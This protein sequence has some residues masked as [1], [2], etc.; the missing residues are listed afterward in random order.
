M[1]NDNLTDDILYH[2][3]IRER[4]S[5]LQQSTSITSND[6]NYHTV[7]HLQQDAEPFRY[8]R[9][10]MRIFFFCIFKV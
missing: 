1:I 6:E 4:R 7:D 10:E 8:Y 9:L 5:K 2:A 3:I